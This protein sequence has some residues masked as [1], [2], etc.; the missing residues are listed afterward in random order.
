MKNLSLYL[1]VFVLGITKINAQIASST[2]DDLSYLLGLSN[3]DPIKNWP[4]CVLP[5][6]I[7][8]DTKDEITTIFWDMEKEEESEY[9]LRF[10]SGLVEN[11]SAIIKT[12]E[13]FYQ[14]DNQFV[15]DNQYS[16]LEIRRVCQ[17]DGDE[18][19]YSD[20]VEIALGY[21]NCDV[22]TNPCP[23]FTYSIWTDCSTNTAVIQYQYS[24]PHPNSCWTNIELTVTSGTN[25]QFSTSSNGS[26]MIPLDGDVIL[27]IIAHP[28]WGYNQNSDDWWPCQFTAP[29]PCNSGSECDNDGIPDDLDNCECVDNPDQTDSDGDGI[30]DLCEAD[31][32]DDGIIDD[33]DNCTCTYNSGQ[34]DFDG[35]GIGDACDETIPLSCDYFS[36][37]ILSTCY[38]PQNDSITNYCIFQWMS[39]LPLSTSE[40]TYISNNSYGTSEIEGLNGAIYIPSGSDVSISYGY[41]YID[42]SGLEQIIECNTTMVLECLPDSSNC[43][44]PNIDLCGFVNFGIEDVEE[45]NSCLFS[46]QSEDNYSIQIEICE[47]YSDGEVCSYYA[48]N[49]GDVI[50]NAPQFSYD[51]LVTY[52]DPELGILT[53]SCSDK[54]VTCSSVGGGNTC[55]EVN[56]L[57]EVLGLLNGFVIDDQTL[58]LVFDGD[59]PNYLNHELWLLGYTP[60]SAQDLFSCVQN[61]EMYFE[62]SNTQ[63]SNSFTD[64]FYNADTDFNV[65]STFSIETWSKLVEG[66]SIEGLSASVTFTV[67]TLEGIIIDC[68]AFELE[69][70]E[71]NPPEED[72]EDPP[73]GLEP[74]D[75]VSDPVAG[76]TLNVALLEEAKCGD[77]F[78]IN[79]FPIVL[80]EVVGGA[81]N[82][83]GKGILPI[84]FGEKFVLVEFSGI[85]VNE[86]S[87]VIDG[88]LNV[89]P[90][91][92]GDYPNFNV[93]YDP[94]VIGGDICLPPP[95]PPGVNADGVDPLTGLDPYG[96]DPQTGIHTN[97]TTFD[98]DG[99]DIDG[100]HVDTGG[101]Y[102]NEG[103]S[104]E[105]FLYEPNTSGEMELTD[106]PCNPNAPT[107]PEIQSF[108]DSNNTKID[109]DISN[110]IDSLKNSY[111]AKLNLLN[112]DSIRTVMDAHISSLETANPNFDSKYI[113]GENNEF[114]NEGLHLNFIE[115]PKKS[116]IFI[117]GRDS[118]V[119]GLEN[120]HVD[121]YTCDESLVKF[122]EIYDL[123]KSICEEPKA[124]EI[125]D[126]I[127]EAIKE[128]TIYEGQ[129][130]MNDDANFLDWL[131]Q[132]IKEF[133]ENEE[134][135]EGLFSMYAPNIDLLQKEIMDIFTPY[136]G[137]YDAWVST[138]EMASFSKEALEEVDFYF[139]QGFEEIKGIPRAFFLREIAKRRAL[140][141][142][143]LPNNVLTLPVEL[144]KQVGSYKYTIY[145][146]AISFKPSGAKLSA[147]LII[148][149]PK[150]GRE[151][152][153]RALN[154]GFGPSGPT[155][156]SK[157]H[158]ANDIEIRLN[159]ASKLILKGTEDTFVSWDCDGFAG[160][161]I[162]TQIEFCRN[163]ITPLDANL[164][165]KPDTVRYRLD[166]KTE[167]DSWLEF[168]FELD[169]EPFAITKYE[170]IKWEINNMVLDFK[171]TSTPNF[172]V[173]E[174]YVSEFSLP[175]GSLGPLWRG[176]YMETLSATFPNKFSNSSEPITV[177][178]NHILIDKSGVSG[179]V[180]AENINILSLEKGNLSGWPF[181]ITDLGIHVLQNNFTG[182]D[183]GGQLK[184]SV[185]KESM[186]YRATVSANN[187][188]RFTVTPPENLYMDMLIA[189]VKLQP[190][191]KIVVTND[192]DEFLCLAHLNGELNVSQEIGDLEIELPPITFQ[193]FKVSNQS[194]YFSPG[195][196]SL[197]L[198]AGAKFGGFELSVKKGKPYAPVPGNSEL[199]GFMLDIGLQLESKFNISAEGGVGLIG[200]LVIDA[201]GKQD[202]KYMDYEVLDFCI[203]TSFPGVKSLTGCLNFFK[204]TDPDNPNGKFGNGFQGSLDA[205]FSKF[206]DEVKVKGMFGKIGTT[207]NNWRYFFVDAMATLSSGIKVGP[208]DINGFGGGISYHMTSD[209]QPEAI[210]FTDDAA[211][212]NVLGQSLSSVVYEPSISTGLGL[213]AAAMFKL[214]KGE[215]LFNG[216]V[217]LGMEFNSDD[218]ESTGLSKLY[219][220]GLGQMLAPVDINIPPTTGGGTSHAPSGVEASLSAYVDL[221]MD[222]NADTFHGEIAAFLDAGFV[223]GDQSRNNKLI[224]AELHFSPDKWYINIGT[225]SERCV[226][227]LN[228]PGLNAKLSAY[229]NIGNDIPNMPELPNNVREIAYK[230][231]S[232]ESLRQSG[233]GIMFGAS[234]DVECHVN[235]YIAEAN[236][237]AGVGFDVMVRKYNNSICQETQEEIGING[238]YGAGQAWAYL[239]GALSV[240]GI[241]IIKAGFAAVV[242]ARLPNPS[243]F[244]GT[245][246][247]RIDTWWKKYS[248]S[249]AIEMGETCTIINTD[250]NDP[251]GM[252]I[253]SLIDPLDGTENVSIDAVPTV[254]F[255][256]P[257]N[258]G[259][260]LPMNEGNAWFEAI[261]E[262]IKITS[263]GYE[264]PV[265]FEPKVGMY[266]IQV[267]PFYMFP[268]NDSIEIHVKVKVLKN[269][270]FIAFQEETSKFYTMEGYD[271]IP[272]SNII[273]SYPMN[274]QYNFYKN[275]RD[276]SY[277]LLKQGMPEIFYDIPEEMD[278]R[279]RITNSEGDYRVMD[280]THDP[281]QNRISFDLTPYIEIDKIYRLE[282]IRLK[283]GTWSESGNISS[284]NALGSIESEFSDSESNSPEQQILYQ[285]FFRSSKYEF[286]H[287]K[288]DAIE[289]IPVK[290]DISNGSVVLYRELEEP[291]GR[292]EVAGTLTTE[293]LVGFNTDPSHMDNTFANDLIDWYHLF[294]PTYQV[295]IAGSNVVFES[296][297]PNRFAY[298]LFFK[299]IR[300]AMNLEYPFLQNELLIQKN[301]WQSGIAPSKDQRLEFFVDPLY[302]IQYTKTVSAS[303]IAVGVVKILG[304]NHDFDLPD[305]HEDIIK[306]NGVLNM[307][308]GV[309]KTH[310]TLR[311]PEN[312]YNDQNGISNGG[313]GWVW[314]SLL[315][316]Y[317]Q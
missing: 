71:E 188:Y 230:V 162:D 311:A 60:E 26:I 195:D 250:P 108:L 279:I 198:S 125:K 212:T 276:E 218:S 314:T 34:E 244:Q 76:D 183:L 17:V 278:Q 284:Q 156:E 225:P 264:I 171:S 174:G 67:T 168:E 256:I 186:D 316:E 291:F 65:P 127:K 179:S 271:I 193:N 203:G 103:C 209:F 196:W 107:H 232:N 92:P 146:D 298:R 70:V 38:Q 4:D 91:S 16:F 77:L 8:F 126:F 205:E 260:E 154:V 81:G 68:D 207:D 36:Y 150:S 200:E 14:I 297:N 88:T 285:L 106:K 223:T 78:E 293:K 215:D 5:E 295:E 148:E 144:S 189:D 80:S 235:A 305:E 59:T 133:A 136:E 43:D 234:F 61:I 115:E 82:F 10:G 185:F 33:I 265:N 269:G 290:K 149:D 96:F 315:W 47:E 7:I 273:A 119:E 104:R 112:C 243:F 226:A 85:T 84:P 12:S 312:K 220:R 46:W 268:A 86:K 27:D 135:K 267:N 287:T 191:S 252:D 266:Q 55:D 246:G 99:F 117:E 44:F 294:D 160:M 263:N 137:A 58:Q 19:L 283:K 233:G 300:S 177:E 114:Y 158:L 89:V 180:I 306:G 32:D 42:S 229:F 145:L 289:A 199:A 187:V 236:L 56:K 90:G 192:G 139:D 261:L 238:W 15:K 281:Q 113:R 262:E 31:C 123:L 224:D 251:V 317:N 83:S 307:P 299:D 2:N 248:G 219:L 13:K 213:N 20:W 93:E 272:E 118:D 172:P 53:S 182:F 30:G 257:M 240:F 211:Y 175:G 228:V 170:D 24:P 282:L 22:Y 1:I 190:S 121:L 87:T 25:T 313:N 231:K 309:Y 308:Y 62:Y 227:Q 48:S 39:D 3:N 270:E 202:W 152:V 157:L 132:K 21:N 253:I 176:F 210:A 258:K 129:N 35:D 249:M 9:E 241:N 161:G 142:S 122:Q 73:F 72:K 75:C 153:F 120:A 304:L 98:D 138:S 169:A 206:L 242:Q 28:P 301:H 163:F 286:L 302:K 100:N 102:N 54:K 95:P 109:L 194:P 255:N 128:W 181:S 110:I 277:I 147:Y 124:T 280:Y 45:N 201:E 164:N 247:Y 222:F 245:V 50:I 197:P 204:E 167:I 259:V 221:S 303:E 134:G 51:Y 155:S 40:I 151:L 143:D 37:N 116:Q 296:L 23:G 69:L 18:E 173:P 130:Y 165:P 208:V 254:Y 57:C 64:Q 237:K 79:G 94:L 63:E 239:E 288:V 111:Q 214:I 6:N 41:S 66:V 274:G 292:Y 49:S 178:A 101:P 140:V 275:Q 131:E 74:L 310:V 11:K 166:V 52:D 97:G 141:D 184:V 159:N 105:G 217:Q 216:T 29:D